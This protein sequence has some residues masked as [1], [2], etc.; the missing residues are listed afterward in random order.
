M[1]QVPSSSYSHLFG[2]IVTLSCCNMASHVQHKP[3]WWDLISP[4]ALNGGGKRRI[5]LL[6]LK[7]CHQCNYVVLTQFCSYFNLCIHFV[8]LFNVQSV[9]IPHGMLSFRFQ[10]SW[11]EWT[12]SW[13]TQP[14]GCTPGL[15]KET[16]P[17]DCEIYRLSSSWRYWMTPLAVWNN[18][19]WD[20]SCQGFAIDWIFFAALWT[21]K[22]YIVLL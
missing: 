13:R 19:L 18:L 14:K 4:L 7:L 21:L 17:A 12:W 16:Q 15:W 11:A 6:L 10:S 8:Y 5:W 2:F 1:T 9:L 22:L 20:Y 3:G